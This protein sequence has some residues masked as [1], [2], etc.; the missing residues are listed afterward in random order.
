MSNVINT[1][2][3]IVGKGISGLVLSLLLQRKGI[4]HLLLDRQDKRKSLALAET[5][6]PSAM[7][8]LDTL[9]LT[10]LFSKSSVKTFGYHSM[11]GSDRVIDNNFFN[12]NPYKYGLKLNK[13]ALIAHLESLVS[14]HIVKCDKV[15][16]I[17]NESDRV[18][19]AAERDSL[20]IN[21]ESKFIVDATGRNRAVLKAIG[22][23]STA[24]DHLIGTTCQLPFMKHPKLIHKVFSE[25]FEQ[26]WGIVSAVDG[27]T[28]AM[29]IFAHKGSAILKQLKHYENWKDAL[30][31]TKI[32]KDFLSNNVDRKVVGGDAN[33]SRATHIAGS[34]WMAIGDAAVAF[35]PLSSHGISNGIYCAKSASEAISAQL[36]DP[37]SGAF[38]Q[39]ESTLRQVFDAYLAHKSQLY[40][41]EKR[42]PDSAFWAEQQLVSAAQ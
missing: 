8:L 35:D 26:G 13:K 22:V 40:L 42:W 1:D 18:M 37:S 30:A 23:D 17:R 31:D 24:F 20:A 12:H 21:I 14:D 10:G 9:D 27:D 34:N 15:S 29:T 4:E 2:I 39:Y 33:S 32:L 28:N 11:W 36:I 38:E 5:M 41:T 25:S 7:A 16:E 19:I 6:P 3:V